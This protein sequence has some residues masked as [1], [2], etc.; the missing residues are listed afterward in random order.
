VVAAA[1]VG[2]PDAHAGE[3]PVAYV[4]LAQAASTGAHELREWAGT[5]VPE[6]ASAPKRVDVI[7]AIPVTAVGKYYKPELR[8]RATED[9]AR[10][11]LCGL[12]ADVAARLQDG[13]V[14]VTVSGAPRSAVEEAL[15]P[16]TFAWETA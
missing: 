4:V 1:A 9:A 15:A 6:P 11:A 10:D 5:H 14:V 3:V 7:D 12:G 16:F 8:R 2:R 13:Q